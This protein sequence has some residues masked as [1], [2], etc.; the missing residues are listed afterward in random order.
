LTYHVLPESSSD[1]SVI[2]TSQPSCVY[3]YVHS[4]PYKS[5]VYT[6]RFDGRFFQLDALS[7][8][9][10]RCDLHTAPDDPCSFSVSLAASQPTRCHDPTCWSVT[11]WYLVSNN[12]SSPA[13]TSTPP[14]C[15]HACSCYSRM[16]SP[17]RMKRCYSRSIEKLR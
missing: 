1:A 11:L 6:Y 2:T 9:C 12:V 17:R 13:T 16:E 3:G 5:H 8:V 7:L 15:K 4:V 10:V 14:C